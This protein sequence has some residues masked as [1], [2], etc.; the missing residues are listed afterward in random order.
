MRNKL[1]EVH[2]EEHL[3]WWLDAGERLGGVDSRPSR[4]AHEEN[5]E[6]DGRVDDDGHKGAA[7]CRGRRRV[8]ARQMAQGAARRVVAPRA[9]ARI[10]R[11]VL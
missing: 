10:R 4:P 8:A 11:L 5:E 7:Q 2:V 1:E 6:A 9:D 3:L